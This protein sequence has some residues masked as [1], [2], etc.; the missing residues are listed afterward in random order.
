MFKEDINVNLDK[1]I[2]KTLELIKY[3]DEDKKKQDEEEEINRKTDML[4]SLLLNTSS[5]TYEEIAEVDAPTDAY[6]T[7]Y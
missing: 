6:I 5:K 1:N 7:T 3:L 4:L 2:M